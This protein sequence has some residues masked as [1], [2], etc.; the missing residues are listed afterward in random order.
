M[1]V[2]DVQLVVDYG[3]SKTM[4]LPTLPGRLAV[5][6]LEKIEGKCCL[7]FTLKVLSFVDELVAMAVVP[8]AICLSLLNKN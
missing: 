4:H 7:R 8:G 1:D 2:S 6:H 5:V 3:V